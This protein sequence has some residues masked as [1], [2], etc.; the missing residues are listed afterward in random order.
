MFWVVVEEC[1]AVVALG[2]LVGV[3]GRMGEISA[4]GR[5]NALSFRPR[6]GSPHGRFRLARFSSQAREVK[7]GRGCE[8]RR[9]HRGKKLPPSWVDVRSSAVVKL[10]TAL[11]EI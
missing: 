10:V 8:T 9:E 4:V 11:G 6:F 7:R 5:P 1:D 3:L 2:A